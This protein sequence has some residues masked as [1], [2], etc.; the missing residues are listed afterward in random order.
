METWVKEGPAGSNMP[1]FF[2]PTK[3]AETDS[4]TPCA[5]MLVHGSVIC[6]GAWL[7]SRDVLVEEATKV[8]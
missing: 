1:C 2:L 4:T 7:K 6:A 8:S 3:P 5:T